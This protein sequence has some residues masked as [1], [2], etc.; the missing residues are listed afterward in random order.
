MVLVEETD[1]QPVG[2]EFEPDQPV[3]A[4]GVSCNFN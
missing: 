4:G 2:I 1:D 3:A